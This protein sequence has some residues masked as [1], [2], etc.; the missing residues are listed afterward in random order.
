MSEV[1]QPLSLKTYLH[2]LKPKTV[3]LSKKSIVRLDKLSQNFI[4]FI[5]TQTLNMMY[6]E[7]RGTLTEKELIT[8][9]EILCV[10][11]GELGREMICYG[12]NSVSKCIDDENRSK[13]VKSDKAELTIGVPRI[14]S[15]VNGYVNNFYLDNQQS[16]FKLEDKKLVKKIKEN[17]MVLEKEI[18][19]ILPKLES[20]KNNK[21]P[22]MF[23][24]DILNSKQA[25]IKKTLDFLSKNKTFNFTIIIKDLTELIKN[26]PDTVK[27]R[28][29]LM[30]LRREI[31][32]HVI[33]LIIA[34]ISKDENKYI[35]QM[36]ENIL[37][38]ENH[39]NMKNIQEFL[40]Y[41]RYLSDE[42]LEERNCI[43]GIRDALQIRPKV[44][45]HV[46][47]FMTGVLEYFINRMLN[48][49]GKQA[50]DDNK[51]KRNIVKEEHM[52]NT[53]NQDSNICN[54]ILTLSSSCDNFVNLEN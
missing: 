34:K 11:K 43:L 39:R 16:N 51:N 30:N 8:T 41:A 36:F 31:M 22:G 38:I 10:G 50:I 46:P 28:E 33:A 48:P 20:K 18:K 40:S 35:I 1:Y 27:S 19:N 53:I 44:S 54:L 42:Y 21:S 9:I 2:K 37:K 29:T 45:K 17:V 49:A 32:N 23:A 14:K 7:K 52:N 5:I 47:V 6:K 26:L 24:Y 4:E 12:L 15:Y 25:Q 3:A 13:R